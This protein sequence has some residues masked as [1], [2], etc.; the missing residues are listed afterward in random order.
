MPAK[1][2]Q[3]REYRRHF[4][5]EWREFSDLS[6]EQAAE[7]LDLSRSQL[8]KIESM[9]SPYKQGLLEAAAEVYG[10]E[11]WDILN[12]NPLLPDAPR[13]ILDTL[14]QTPPDQRQEIINYIEFLRTKA[15]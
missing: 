5:R 2:H 11:P 4:F 3:K 6:Q 14:E 13:S 9:Q 1:A 7:R 15:G 12:R 8:S 10:C